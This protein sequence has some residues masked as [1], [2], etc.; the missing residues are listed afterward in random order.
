MDKSELKSI[1][2]EYQNFS[3]S[4][5]IF[6]HNITEKL[7]H[8][9]IIFEEYDEIHPS[10]IFVDVEVKPS[11]SHNT[12]VD[13]NR[14]ELSN[15][16]TCN[17][18]INSLQ[19]SNTDSFQKM[20][21]S[22]FQTDTAP[23]NKTL[24][25]KET[26]TKANKETPNKETPNKGASNKEAPNK[27][28]FNEKLNPEIIS[29]IHLF[30]SGFTHSVAIS[31]RKLNLSDILQIA[32]EFDII[33]DN[34][35]QRIE[36]E[37]SSA[38][39]CLNYENEKYFILDL[40]QI[41]KTKFFS[42]EKTGSISLTDIENLLL[43][44]QNNLKDDFILALSFFHQKL[45]PNIYDIKLNIKSKCQEMIHILNEDLFKLNTNRKSLKRSIDLKQINIHVI[46]IIILIGLR[47]LMKIIP[48]ITKEFLDL[49]SLFKFFTPFNDKYISHFLKT[50]S[51]SL[52]FSSIFLHFP[53]YKNKETIEF[54]SLL[55]NC[56]NKIQKIKISMKDQND[57]EKQIFLSIFE[58]YLTEVG[59]LNT[60]KV[61][62]FG[63]NINLLHKFKFQPSK[64]YLVSD[65]EDNLSST[66]NGGFVG[67][68]HNTFLT[69]WSI[70]MNPDNK[71]F[72]FHH[73]WDSGIIKRN[74]VMFISPD[75]GLIEDST[76]SGIVVLRFYPI[77]YNL[78]RKQCAKNAKSQF[79]LLGSPG[80]GKSTM[81]PYIVL[82]WYQV[83][84]LLNEDNDPIQTIIVKPN[85]LP[86]DK[87]KLSL[88]FHRSNDSLL[89]GF[90]KKKPLSAYWKDQIIPELIICHSPNGNN[91]IAKKQIFP[92]SQK[93][94][95]YLLDEYIDQY[96]MVGTKSL[97]INS[98]GS[99]YSDSKMQDKTIYSFLPT[100]NELRMIASLIKNPKEQEKFHENRCLIGFSIRASIIQSLYDIQLKIKDTVKRTETKIFTNLFSNP[101][102]KLDKKIRN[103]RVYLLFIESRL[104][105]GSD[106]YTY[107]NCSYEDWVIFSQY[108]F[109]FGS[110]MIL[111]YL[112][113]YY[114]KTKQNF[115]QI[116]FD[117]ISEETKL[118]K[119]KAA[120]FDLDVNILQNPHSFIF[121][122]RKLTY[123]YDQSSKN[124]YCQ[125]SDMITQFILNIES[126]DVEIVE[127]PEDIFTSERNIVYYLPP[128]VNEPGIDAAYKG[129]I[130]SQM[131]I[132][133]L[134]LTVSD[135]HSFHMGVFKYFKQKIA[136]Y[137]L[138]A[139][140]EFWAVTPSLINNFTF[141]NLKGYCSDSKDAKKKTIGVYE[142]LIGDQKSITL[143]FCKYT[144]V[145][146]FRHACRITDSTI[147]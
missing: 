129:P 8:N 117:I 71:Y 113:E 56:S 128:T 12:V 6:S 51:Q 62:V 14:L 142:P 127:N 69:T 49:K 122:T 16:E 60:Q 78:L 96:R 34:F 10:K 63:E 109:Q 118:Q 13:S 115:K 33:D 77:L 133:L 94:T 2:S 27:E 25:N 101:T 110:P 24:S 134:Q 121:Q 31:S 143:K 47:E 90:M 48:I 43:F 46:S 106:I 58:P 29:A 9:A 126:S 103:L 54:L 61:I 98:I 104:P 18:D 41:S 144:N 68:F 124:K 97:I 120:F 37:T 45:N 105:K 38:I 55:S 82:R 83:N 59:S 28:T 140:L 30:F 80:T 99:K 136:E 21:V 138:K 5:K 39:H 65:K 40:N 125:E 74:N 23:P 57:N 1:Q 146:T 141:S 26:P 81:I 89:F 75:F 145:Y 86:K 76:P 116:L 79:A 53:K 88:F 93:R 112:K 19:L 64:F 22:Y 137:K 100:T 102:E 52:L 73:V 67:V 3:L 4:P 17:E 85:K 135:S 15:R 91:T 139:K 20:F 107:F 123:N 44:Y 11:K 7:R 35:L 111:R 147:K 131:T 119:M 132:V 84:D 130:N 50:I 42:I 95:L 66:V 108:Y 87:P 72:D 70:L 36:N 32:K 114:L 92:I